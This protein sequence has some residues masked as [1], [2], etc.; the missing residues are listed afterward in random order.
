MCVRLPGL[1]VPL[2]LADV[3]EARS[4]WRLV[5]GCDSGSKHWAGEG[6]VEGC[7]SHFK[8][9]MSACWCAWAA[10]GVVCVMEAPRLHPRAE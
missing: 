10:L 9:E 2:V 8:A 1:S 4:K 5:S 6:W 7:G 3:L